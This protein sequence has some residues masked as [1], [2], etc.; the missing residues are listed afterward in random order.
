MTDRNSFDSPWKEILG[1]YFREFMIFFFP[2]IEKEIDWEKGY[3]PLDKELHQITRESDTGNRI[4]DRLMQVWKK[5][6]D[7]TWVMAHTEI[8]GGKEDEFPLR[9]FVYNYRGRDL[10]GRSVVSLAVL[11]D[12][13]P[14]WRVS[15]YKDELW[16][17]RTVFSFPS[18]KLLDY[19]KDPTYL[20]SSDNPFA[21]AVMAHLKTL[22][23]RKD[24]QSRLQYKLSLSR[25]LYRHGWSKDDIIRLYR[26][27]DWIMVLPAEMENIY[28]ENLMAYER[29][30]NMQYITT[31]ERIGMEKG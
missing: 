15:E 9:V 4:A 6:G 2:E 16:G 3:V 12:T 27:I 10:Y 29:E 20:E 11:T 19:K 22:E 24:R 21:V 18:V 25:Q 30:V 7:E 28:H 23:T 5:N 1:A 8:Q 26:F 17:C 14:E 13:N 31:A